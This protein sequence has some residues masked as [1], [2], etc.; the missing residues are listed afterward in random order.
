[1]TLWIVFQMF[2]PRSP[3]GLRV[4][5]QQVGH[6]SAPQSRHPETLDVFIRYPGIFCLNGEVVKKT[7]L[8]SK[9]RDE[10]GR[11]AEWTVYV[12]ADY[13]TQFADTAFAI[14]TIQGLGGEVFWITP[15]MRKEW[16][17]ATGWPSPN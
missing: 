6:I 8:E 11:R 16:Q 17:Q 13:D 7:E 1:M 10:L 3:M 9:M 14:D 4:D 12:E 2:Q 5:W 15:A